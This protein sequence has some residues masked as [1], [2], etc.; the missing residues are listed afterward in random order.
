M[1]SPS[2]AILIVG[3]II[4]ALLITSVSMYIYNSAVGSITGGLSDSSTDDT[5]TS[6]S[7]SSSSTDDTVISSSISSFR[8][9]EVMAFNANFESYEGNQTGSNVKSLITRLI[10]NAKTYKDDSEKV[11][12]VYYDKDDTTVKYD[13]DIDS[14]IEELTRIRNEVENKHTY[15]IEMTYQDSGFLDTIKILYGEAD[16]STAE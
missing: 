15:Q 12:T 6:S 3:V 4:V 1:F 13:S 9:Q 14:Y 8:E 11:V 10:A 7:V 2:K 5:V 16:S